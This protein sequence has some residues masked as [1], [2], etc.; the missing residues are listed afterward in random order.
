MYKS[1]Y[2]TEPPHNQRTHKSLW[3]ASLRHLTTEISVPIYGNGHKNLLT[4]MVRFFSNQLPINTLSSIM[5]FELLYKGLLSVHNIDKCLNTGNHENVG[6]QGKSFSP[7]V[8][9]MHCQILWAKWTWGHVNHSKGYNLSI[10][11]LPSYGLWN[12]EQ[13][14]DN[15]L[16]YIGPHR[17]C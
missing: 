14:N 6:N 10:H 4:F 15:V 12:T 16:H 2:W 11:K 3:N 13:C 7:G 9:P 5:M 1:F 17:N 8:G